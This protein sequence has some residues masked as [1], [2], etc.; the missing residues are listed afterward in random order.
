M[1]SVLF[2]MK[3]KII[4]IKRGNVAVKIYVSTRTKGGQCYAEYKVADKSTGT[5]RLLPF[6]NEEDA[7]RKATEIVEGTVKTQAAEASWTEQQKREIVDSMDLVKPFGINL[8]TAV[9]VFCQAIEI[10]GGQ[11]GHLLVAAQFYKTNRP[12]KPLIPKL[13]S[14]VVQEYLARRKML[15]TERQRN[16]ACNLGHFSKKFAGRTLDEIA[17][18]E[19]SDFV[20]TREWK[21][22]TVNDFLSAVSLLYKDGILHNYAAT[23][24]CAPNL[25]SRPRVRRGK[26]EI[27]TPDEVRTIMASLEDGLCIAMALW[28]WGATRISEVARLDWSVLRTAL[29]TGYI[30]IEVVENNELKT[31]D[32]Q[33]SIPLS[34][35]LRA[36]IE[37]YLAMH[38]DARGRVLPT[39]YSAGRK[40]SNLPRKI[41]CRSKIEWKDN[42]ARHSFCTYH[43]KAYKDI[44]KLVEI[45]GNSVRSL[46]KHYWNKSNTIT[47]QMA[48]EYFGI[49]PPKEAANLIPMPISEA[50]VEPQAV[51]S[52]DE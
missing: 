44:P 38:P 49:L 1:N 25:I 3:S 15:S 12:N 17:A 18:A 11:P 51:S 4:E 21:P 6:S 37:W 9:T 52:R 29:K 46:Q 16:L 42:G 31:E 34:S 48:A 32:S 50:P 10:M 47:E 45:A 22:K 26:I 33:R 36:W 41:V 8:K 5:R 13:A 28:F 23:N 35:T 7:R 20:A 14:E 2:A 30:V 27:F 39:R 24:P 43:L 40:L 19:I